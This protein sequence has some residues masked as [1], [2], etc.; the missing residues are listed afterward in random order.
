MEIQMTAR[1]TG[2]FGELNRKRRLDSTSHPREY[3]KHLV[4]IGVAVVTIEDKPEP[5]IEYKAEK[6]SLEPA[7]QSSSSPVA[8]PLP[9]KM[10]KKLKAMMS[11]RST[12][13][14]K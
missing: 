14:T 8:P 3:L 10:S 13:T 2:P 4:A 11:S 6:K 9:K 1:A 7:K 5:A 12:P